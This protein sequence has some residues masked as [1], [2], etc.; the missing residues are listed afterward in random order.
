MTIP[1]FRTAP[2]TDVIF[3]TSEAARQG[4]AL[5]IGESASYGP[6]TERRFALGQ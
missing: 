4:I 1:G 6:L 2:K 5:L 3:V